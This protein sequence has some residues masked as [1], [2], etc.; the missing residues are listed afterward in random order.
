MQHF[1][2]P[3]IPVGLLILGKYYFQLVSNFDGIFLKDEI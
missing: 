2:D 3:E 1:M